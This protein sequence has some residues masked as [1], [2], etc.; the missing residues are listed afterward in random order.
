MP[1]E[2][3][4]ALN[5]TNGAGYARRCDITVVTSPTTK[6][7]F[8]VFMHCPVPLE[9]AEALLKKCGAIKV[10]IVERR[11]DY[12]FWSSCYFHHAVRRDDGVVDS[13]QRAA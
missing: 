12:E 8:T 1:T 4:E 7:C 11:R 5:S 2:E 6:H 3:F 10:M 9:T 13:W